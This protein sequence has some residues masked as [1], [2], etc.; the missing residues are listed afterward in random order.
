M[1]YLNKAQKETLISL[2][3]VTS[4]CEELATTEW[5]KDEADKEKLRQAHKLTMEVMESLESGIDE[6]QLKGVLR[7]AN[8]CVLMVMPKTNPNVD[9]D[10]VI[11]DRKTL[12]RIVSDSLNE[13][14]FCEKRGPQVKNCQRRKDLLECGV[15]GYGSDCPYQM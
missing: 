7:Y 12:S 8:N 6:D 2:G 3:G 11:S 14:Y 15:L 1:S 9:A 4:F 5:V 10:L 13:C